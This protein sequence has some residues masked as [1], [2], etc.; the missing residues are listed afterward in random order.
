MKRRGK[1]KKLR[2]NLFSILIIVVVVTFTVKA[3]SET[4][5][6]IGDAAGKAAVISAG[7]TLPEGGRTLF[8]EEI[9]LSADEDTIT[10]D[11]PLQS[12]QV[13]TEQAAP[14]SETPVVETDSPPTAGISQA[15]IDQFPN[16]NGAVVRKTYT[17]GTTEDYI[18]ISGNAYVRNM[19]NL[20]NQTVIDA[21]H[22]RPAFTI[23]ADSSE[24]QVLI[25]HTH[26]TESYAL[27]DRDYYDANYPS[28]NLDESRN[29]VRVG[30]EITKQLEAAGIGVIH[31]K[32]VHDYPSYNGS[33]NRSR[34]TVEAILAQYPSIKVVLDI[35]RDAIETDDGTR[36][37]PVANINGRNAAQIMIISGCD[38]GTMNYPNYLQNLA[39]ASALQQQVEADYPGLTRPASF[40]YKYYNQSL[41]TG[42]LLIEVGSHANSLDEA[43]YTGYL[44]GKSLAKTLQGLTG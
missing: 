7:L 11:D 5:P 33:Y 31:D 30:D 12:A 10:P 40:K 23:T 35:H 44:L 24:P 6:L 26:T 4:V 14:V 43:L 25:M 28:R 15:E 16:N 13:S 41:T 39:F 8:Q 20:P 3:L 32:T 38:D 21:V 42:S 17:A 2:K 9:D 36:Y 37:A 29:I 18:N 27:S 19:T 22:S 1:Y 34:Q